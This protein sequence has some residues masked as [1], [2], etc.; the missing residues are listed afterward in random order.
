MLRRASTS[1]SG[2]L[3]AKASANCLSASFAFLRLSCSLVRTFG[4]ES[5]GRSDSTIDVLLEF[6]VVLGAKTLI[7]AIVDFMSL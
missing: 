4:V 7:E 5:L 6:F 2:G 3:I 1:G